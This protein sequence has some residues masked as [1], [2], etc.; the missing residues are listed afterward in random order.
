[1]N[2]PGAHIRF[3]T[4]S[5]PPA[6]C[7]TVSGYQEVFTEGLLDCVPAPSLGFPVYAHGGR[8]PWG[9]YLTL[10]ENHFGIYFVTKTTITAQ[11]P[12]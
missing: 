10:P 12:C 5:W 2:Q 4:R 1:M 11:A 7:R 6:L 3:S 8:T 9:T